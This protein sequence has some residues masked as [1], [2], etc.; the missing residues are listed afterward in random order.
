MTP[1][2]YLIAVPLS[3]IA[4]S[5]W[6]VKVEND[7]FTK[8]TRTSQIQQVPNYAGGRTAVGVQPPVSGELTFEHSRFAWAKD[9]GSAPGPLGEDVGQRPLG[10]RALPRAH[11]IDSGNAAPRAKSSKLPE[12]GDFREQPAP[13]DLAFEAVQSGSGFHITADEATRVDMGNLK[14]VFRGRVSLSSPQFHLTGEELVVHLGKD[15]TSFK[16][17][18]AK[19]AVNVQLTG[20]P[21]EKRYRG[22]S[23]N[24]VYDPGKGTLVMTGWPKIQGQGQELVAAE[25]STRV[26]L[27]PKTG[28]MLTEGRAQTRVAKRLMEEAGQGAGN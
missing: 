4:I 22:Q 1:S 17:M 24:A 19:G 15:R 10:A 12:I 6:L 2:T 18:E 21:P 14:V 7:S 11:W 9:D 23:Q 20:V 13:E 28:K 27:Y 5:G 3:L 8:G 25:Q 16:M 26:L